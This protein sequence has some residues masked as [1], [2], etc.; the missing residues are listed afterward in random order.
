MRSSTAKK[1]QES[2]IVHIEHVQAEIIDIA[3][4]RSIAQIAEAACHIPGNTEPCDFEEF[5]NKYDM[6]LSGDFE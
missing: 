5:M 2:Q 3:Q 1:F 4:A 6:K